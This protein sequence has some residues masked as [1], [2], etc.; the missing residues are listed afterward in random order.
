MYKLFIPYIAFGVLLTG[1]AQSSTDKTA[2]NT[3]DTAQAK[4]SVLYQIN[5]SD[6]TVKWTAFKFTARTGVSGTLDSVVVSYGEPQQKIADA[7][8]NIK[9]F[10]PI[11]GINSQNPDRDGKIKERLFGTLNISGITARAVGVNGDEKSGALEVA[12]EMNGVTKSAIF[13]YMIEGNRAQL[14]G[15]I[16][17][18]DWNLLPGVEALNKVCYDLHKGADGVSKLWTDVDFEITAGFQSK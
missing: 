16:N 14:K 3:G 2:D 11:S 9:I 5:T 17:L 13:N 1:C 8:R 12:I 4:T 15:S 18:A 6:V 10:L 7:L